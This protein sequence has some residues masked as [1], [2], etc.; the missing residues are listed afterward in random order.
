MQK[1]KS[2]NYY[3]ILEIGTDASQEEIER[4]YRLTKKALSDNSLAVYSLFDP[5]ETE[6][7]LQKIEEAYI[8][9]SSSDSKRRYDEEVL[10][11]KR[12]PDVSGILESTSSVAMDYRTMRSNIDL[13]SSDKVMTDSVS[14][15]SKKPASKYQVAVDKPFEKRVVDNEFEEEMK[16]ARVFSGEFLRKIREYR[17]ITIK[18]ISTITKINPEY[19]RAIEDFNLLAL[20]PRVYLIGFLRQYTR[21]LKLDPQKVVKSYLKLVEDSKKG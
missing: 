13:K 21:L 7:M 11:L 12:Y 5:G 19:I 15:R 2:Q 20:P 1:S 16:K 14:V 10:G 6:P 9:L 3:E 18:E 17:R 8:V 4:A